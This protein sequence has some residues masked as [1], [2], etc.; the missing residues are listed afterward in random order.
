MTLGDLS[1]SLTS[2]CSRRTATAPHRR[3][4]WHWP[5]KIWSY[6]SP[7]VQESWHCPSPERGSSSIG[8]R[9]T[10]SVTTETIIQYFESAHPNIYPIYKWLECMKILVLKNHSLS[11]SNTKGNS[12]IPKRSFNEDPVLIVYQKPKA[13]NHTNKSLHSTILNKVFLSKKV[14]CVTHCISLCHQGVLHM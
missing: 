11:I 10:N 7:Q 5:W 13:L 2:C 8:P 14:Y 4:L 12:R 9:L 3:P 1:L 6:P